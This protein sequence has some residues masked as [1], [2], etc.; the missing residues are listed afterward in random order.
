MVVMTCSI[1]RVLFIIISITFTRKFNIGLRILMIVVTIK[2]SKTVSVVTFQMSE[3]LQCSI[4]T[5]KYVQHKTLILTAVR[6]AGSPSH[7]RRCSSMN[8]Q[9]LPEPKH[10]VRTIWWLCKLHVTVYIGR[11]I[12]VLSIRFHCWNDAFHCTDTNIIALV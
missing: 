8:Q 1:Q 2:N 3:T 7:Y 4:W 9:L 11:N 5:P 12:I 6:N 10:S